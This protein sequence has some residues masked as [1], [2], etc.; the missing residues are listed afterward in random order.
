[1]SITFNSGLGWLGKQHS[2]M[3]ELRLA[4]WDR[5]P[6]TSLD[7][8]VLAK[9][10]EEMGREWVDMWTG[11]ALEWICVLTRGAMFFKG[12]LFISHCW[13][14]AMPQGETSVLSGGRLV[15]KVLMG[16]KK[17]FSYQTET[18]FNC[19]EMSS[20]HLSSWTPERKKRETPS[21]I[22]V[23]SAKTNLLV[24]LFCT[25]IFFLQ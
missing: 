12:H 6:T 7:R 19:F 10:A 1:M 13:F 18:W 24:H 8:S 20:S 16:G 5:S 14:L 21:S 25:H 9:R 11:A 23:A 17:T 3:T 22:R 4:L 15:L 2:G